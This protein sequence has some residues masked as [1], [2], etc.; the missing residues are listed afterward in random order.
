MGTWP[1]RAASCTTAACQQEDCTQWG[2]IRGILGLYDGKKMEATIVYR[3][4]MQI[5][6]KENAAIDYSILG[7]YGDNG[8]CKLLWYIEVILGYWK[9]TWKLLYCNRHW[10]QPGFGP[11][12]V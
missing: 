2:N 8:K 11:G 5:M 1:L 12:R 3:G 4:Y 9:R 10:L 6:E 7:L